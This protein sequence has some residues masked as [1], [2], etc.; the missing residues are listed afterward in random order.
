MALDKRHVAPRLSHANVVALNYILRF[1]IIVSE[2]RQLRAVHLILDF[3]PI[4][5]IFQDIGNA[6]RASDT[7]LARIDISRPSFLARDDLPPIVFP[8][9]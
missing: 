1:E 7:W 3:E 8:L 9:Q 6:I 2:D 5:K 4:S